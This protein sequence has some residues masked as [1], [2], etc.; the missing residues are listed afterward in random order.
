M[1]STRQLAREL[2][3]GEVLR[4]LIEI[5]IAPAASIPASPARSTGLPDTPTNA[6]TSMSGGNT[7][8][9][10]MRILSTPHTQLLTN[11]GPIKLVLMEALLVVHWSVIAVLFYDY[12]DAIDDPVAADASCAKLGAAVAAMFLNKFGEPLESTISAAETSRDSASIVARFR[13]TCM[14]DMEFIS[15]VAEVLERGPDST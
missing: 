2:G 15:Q 10:K 6:F 8:I 12:A 13:E 7:P 9:E 14:A 5:P 4:L 1:Q 3:A 11:S